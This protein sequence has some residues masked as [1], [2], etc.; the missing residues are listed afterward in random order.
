MKR[1]KKANTGHIKTVDGKTILP[2]AYHC[3]MSMRNRCYN[4]KHISYKD[5]GAK[6]VTVCKRWYDSYVNFI[7]DIGERPSKEHSLDRID[8]TGNY[9]PSN[10]KWST[11][12]EQN[13]NKSNNRLVTYKGKTKCVSQWSD[14]LGLNFQ[15]VRDRILKGFTPEK[16][17]RIDKIKDKRMVLN[18]ETGVYYGTIVESA[19]SCGIPYTTLNSY[20]N[21]KYPNK[22]AFILI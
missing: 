17:F 22:T 8:S 19:K 11:R 13:R 16:A 3:W 4:P 20:L 2:K 5:Y 15:L 6:G 9:E 18:T 10:C 7:E 21:G 12:T 1:I 14:D